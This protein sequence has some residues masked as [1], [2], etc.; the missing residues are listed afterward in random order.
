MMKISNKFIQLHELSYLLHESAEGLTLDDIQQRYGVSL[1]TAQRWIKDIR[2]VYGHMEEF[3]L[4]GRKIRWRISGRSLNYKLALS[5]QDLSLLNISAELLRKHNLAEHAEQLITL[6]TKLKNIISLHKQRKKL[7]DE[8]E[9]LLKIEGLAFRPGPRFHLDETILKSLRTALLNKQQIKIKYYN[10]S[11]DKHSYNILEPYGILYSERNHYLLARHS[12]NYY[13]DEIHHFI[14][15]NIKSIELLN[16]HYQL[17]DGFNLNDYCHDMF[18]A[19]KEPSFDVEWLFDKQVA[20]EV[21]HYFFHPSQRMIENKDGS[22]T[23][24]FNAGGAVEMSW[25]LYMWGD[26]VNV[27]KP[28]DFWQRI[29]EY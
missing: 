14:L 25:F 28:I 23:I 17:P 9:T 21:K 29:E 4:D 1:R 16:L 8:T 19:F 7:E 5:A 11:S 10:K 12:D 6:K 13:G 2:E 3:S 18:G 26:M 24:K 22:I 15:H 20:N 27:I